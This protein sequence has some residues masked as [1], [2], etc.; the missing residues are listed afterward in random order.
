[1]T[2]EELQ[3]EEKELRT[4]VA[5][6]IKKQRELNRVLLI[7]LSGMNIGDKVLY[8][9]KEA[10][11]CGFT[12]SPSGKVLFTYKNINKSGSLAKLEKVLYFYDSAKLLQ[13]DFMKP[14]DFQKL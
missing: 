7:E 5:Q 11:I 2:L 8:R 14:E 3:K 4:L 10:I 1:M 6:N 13:K 9:R 12:Y